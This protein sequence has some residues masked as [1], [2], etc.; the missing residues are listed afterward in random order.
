MALCGFVE[1]IPDDEDSYRWIARKWPR[2]LL[3]ELRETLTYHG[4]EEQY[5]RYALQDD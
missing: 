5:R 1:H 2:G 3:L 4:D